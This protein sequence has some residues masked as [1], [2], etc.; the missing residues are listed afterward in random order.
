MRYM[1]TFIIVLGGLG[2]LRASAWLLQ[3]QRK[4]RSLP[5]S[6][7]DAPSIT[8]QGR[9]HPTR[10]MAPAA[11]QIS[12][13]ELWGKTNPSAIERAWRKFNP[14]DPADHD[15]EEKRAYADFSELLEESYRKLGS[16]TIGNVITGTVVSRDDEGLFIDLGHKSDAFCPYE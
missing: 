9:S 5:V 12:R 3:W 8:L 11:M 6:Q 13:V 2:A 14:T 7:D 10:R 4:A 16:L 15:E 1:L